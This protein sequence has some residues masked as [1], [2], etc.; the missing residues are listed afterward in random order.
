MR[1]REVRHLDSHR[2][3][4]RDRRED[5][6]LRRGERV[7]EVVLEPRDLRDLRTR[8][9]LELVAHDARAGDRPDDRRVDSEVR[10]RLD[11][12]PR[13]ALADIR[14][15]AP[16]RRARPQQRHGRAAGSPRRSRARRRRAAPVL[17]RRHVVGL[18]RA[19]SGG[20][21]AESGPGRD[22]V[23][24]CLIPS[25]ARPSS[26]RSRARPATR[27]RG[28]R[29]RRSSRPTRGSRA[30]GARRCPPGGRAARAPRTAPAE[31]PVTRSAPAMNE[32][33]ADDQRAGLADHVSEAAAE[34]AADGA[35]FVIAERDHEARRRRRE[36]GAERAQVDEL[37]ADEHQPADAEEHER[38]RRRRRRRTRR[39]ASPRRARRRAPVPAEPQHGREDEPD[40]DHPE[41]PELGMV[42]RLASSARAAWLARR[43]R[44]RRP[45]D[46]LS[47]GESCAILRRA[48]RDRDRGRRSA[49]SAR[50]YG[51]DELIG[52]RTGAFP[53]GIFVVNVTGAF[54]IGSQSRC[55][56]RGS[57]TLGAAAVVT[58]FLGAYTTFSTFSLDTYRLLERGGRAGCAT[59]RH[60][61]AGLVAVWLGLTVGRL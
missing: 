49:R 11:E 44:L 10:E 1:G 51:L 12:Q 50:R 45:L 61:R 46:V 29:R 47:P 40:R 21:S 32:R 3:L 13:G 7:G 41:P 2:L 37:A 9:E 23:G 55:S 58:G 31:A 39:R 35:S 57:R 19:A 15:V 54:L 16:G 60:A 36:P 4:A 38:E 56:S 30:S 53:W 34:R 20:G 14:R 28:R 43:A 59:R 26:R 42:V 6:D 52:R 27:R 25:P 33:H 17:P 22:H 5:A 18:G 24:V 48:R 8:R